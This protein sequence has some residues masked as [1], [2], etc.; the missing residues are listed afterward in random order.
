MLDSKRVM[1]KNLQ[2]LM[3]ING[4]SRKDVCEGIGVSYTTFTDWV[5]GNAYPRPDKV[6]KLAAY[7]NI[8]RS[9]LMEPLVT[10]NTTVS[11]D[12]NGTINGSINNGT[13]NNG[14]IN[15][16]IIT[17]STTENDTC[18]MYHALSAEAKGQIDNLVKMLH[19]MEN[20]K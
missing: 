20:K 17:P 19:D 10:S 13:I 8:P 7:F 5:K 2:K 9:A 16:N 4:K 12:N 11:G 6:E 15:G 3:N 14:T 18:Q 1:A